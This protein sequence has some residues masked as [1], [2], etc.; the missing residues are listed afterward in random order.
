MLHSSCDLAFTQAKHTRPSRIRIKVFVNMRLL[1]KICAPILHE[2]T[3]VQKHTRGQQYIKY[4]SP[5][6]NSSLYQSGLNRSF[7]FSRFSHFS[8]SP[9]NFD[10]QI[11]Q[12]ISV[13]SYHGTLISCYPLVLSNLFQIRMEPSP[14]I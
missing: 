6:I 14:K 4:I 2:R 1:K 5:N 11:T 8:L 3:C 12:W 9:N 13:I 7:S 10:I